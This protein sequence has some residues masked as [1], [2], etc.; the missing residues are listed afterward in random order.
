L[1]A[2]ERILM[3]NILLIGL[4]AVISILMIGCSS[5]KEVKKEEPPPALPPPVVKKPTDPDITFKIASIDLGKLA[6][7]IEI[8]DV[9]ALNSELKKQKIDILTF[10]GVSRYPQVA[11]RVDIIDSLSSRADMRTIFG[12]TIELSGRQNGNAI[13]CSYPIRSNENTHYDGLHSNNFEAA[14]QAVI[15]C[16][17]RDVT[18]VSTG[19]PEAMTEDDKRTIANKMSSFGIQYL[20]EPMII[21]G[22]LPTPDELRTSAQYAT[23][24]PMSFD[25]A[26]R[27]WFSTGGALKL[28]SQSIASTAVGAMT[29][30]EFGLFRK[31]QP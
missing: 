13:L 26:P 29:V 17:A 16:G 12:V 25:D 28:L 27:I 10:Q 6:K 14:L 3:K 22:N 1:R 30:A 2:N 9:D 20:N 15:D 5:T 31:P 11:T 4:V 8:K 19:L 21:T 18:I 7:R 24:K 23:L